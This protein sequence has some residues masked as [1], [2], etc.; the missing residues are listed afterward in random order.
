LLEKY[1]DEGVDLKD[2]KVLQ[3]RPLNDYGSPTEIIKAFGGKAQYL[4]AV[5]ALDKE[6]YRMA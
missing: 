4:E 2:I 3:L 6:V 5:K 1:A